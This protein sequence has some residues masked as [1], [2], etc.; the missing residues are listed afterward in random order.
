MF[1]AVLFDLDDTLMPDEA[2]ANEALVA[3]AALAKQTP[4]RLLHVAQ[5][6]REGFTVEEGSGGMP[7]A[8]SAG[9][10][11]AAGTIAA[12]IPPS[13]SFV[14]YGLLTGDGP[15][16]VANAITLVSA[17]LILDRK[18]R[19]YR[20]DRR[21]ARPLARGTDHPQ[22]PHRRHQHAR[23]VVAQPEPGDQAEREG[24]VGKN[25]EQGISGERL[26]AFE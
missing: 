4:D 25:A 16:I 12:L 23:G 2:A 19:A 17:G 22:Q 6:F 14:I 24:T 11:A 20:A 9:C 3:T 21:R 5:A 7:T 18:W 15:L 13:I 8:F 26:V 10:I 1:K